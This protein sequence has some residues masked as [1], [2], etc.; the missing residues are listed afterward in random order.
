MNGDYAPYPPSYIAYG[1][2]SAVDQKE[3]AYKLGAPCMVQNSHS[4][5]SPLAGNEAGNVFLEFVFFYCALKFR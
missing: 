5:F 3:S 4:L 2:R 1:V